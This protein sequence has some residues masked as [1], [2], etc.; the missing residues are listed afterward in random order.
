VKEYG[1]G[2]IEVLAQWCGGAE[3]KHKKFQSI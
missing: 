2:V 3:E 1:R